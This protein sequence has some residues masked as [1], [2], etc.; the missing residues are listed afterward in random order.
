MPILSMTSAMKW[1]FLT[2]IPL[3]T[4][5]G[6]SESFIDVTKNQLTELIR[7]QYNRAIC[8]LLGPGK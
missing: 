8:L 3:V 5:I 2:E 4:L 7:Q 1:S 6:L